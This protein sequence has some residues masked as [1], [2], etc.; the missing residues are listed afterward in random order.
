MTVLAINLANE[1][2]TLRLSNV[3]DV[4]RAY[5]LEGDADA[6]ASLTGVGGLL[7]T[8]VKLN[9]S[10]LRAA[11][12]LCAREPELLQQTAPLLKALWE[13]SLLDKEALLAWAAAPPPSGAAG[14]ATQRARRY[15]TPFT[16][17]LAS[18]PLAAED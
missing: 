14:V 10:P 16:E 2:A 18:A 6:R 1:S 15:A 17:W 8:G 11:A 12:E 5:V 9:G 3:G 7:G 4:A 13:A